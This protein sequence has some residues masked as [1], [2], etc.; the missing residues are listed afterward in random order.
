ML[1]EI[2][3]RSRNGEDIH[4]LTF[5]PYCC[6]KANEWGAFALNQGGTV[7]RCFIP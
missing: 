4:E 3:L 7:E 2:I 6:V 5:C 1:A